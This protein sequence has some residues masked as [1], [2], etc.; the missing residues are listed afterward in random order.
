MPKQRML[1][2]EIH[3]LDIA[4]GRCLAQAY[5]AQQMEDVTCTNA[6]IIRF[7]NEHP[8]RD[9][10]QRDLEKEFGITRSTA[11]RVLMLMEQ[12]GL[13][14]R[15]GVKEDARLKK[16]VLTEKSK[17]ISAAMRENGRNMDTRL[18]QGFSEEEQK[19][20]YGFLDRMLA[21]VK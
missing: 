12:K 21:N 10:Y 4:I 17:S 20:L 14:E 16:L 7:V 2:K 1:A 9:V 15:H 19:Q 8:E 18:L 5:Q 11:S 3:R 13:I 6:R